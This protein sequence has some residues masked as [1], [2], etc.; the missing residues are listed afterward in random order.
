[1]GIYSDILAKGEGPLKDRGKKDKDKKKGKPGSGEKQE[2]AKPEPIEKKIKK[3]KKKKDRFYEKYENLP[4][5]ILEAFRGLRTNLQ[6][7]NLEKSIKTLLV[8]GTDKEDGKTLT[9]AYLA[10][11]LAK[12]GTKVLIVDTALKSPTIHKA[13]GLK[14]SPGLTDLLANKELEWES[15]VQPTD[16]PNLKV[17]SSGIIKPESADTLANGRLG[18]LIEDFKKNYDIVLFDSSH[19]LEVADAGVLARKVNGVVLVVRSGKTHRDAL[20]R[21]KTQFENVDAKVVGIVF[22]DVRSYLPRVIDHFLKKYL[23]I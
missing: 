20:A 16:N 21:V 18:P 7:L 3:D 23:H 8:A 2:G 12:A 17:L 13:F 10:T 15:F 5:H 22:N 9:V 4:P 11:A 14:Q 1:M 6:F 19:G